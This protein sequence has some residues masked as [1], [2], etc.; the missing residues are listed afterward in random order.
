MAIAP[1]DLMDEDGEIALP[2]KGGKQLKENFV[3]NHLVITIHGYP[4]SF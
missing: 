2:V 3:G 4:F 1:C